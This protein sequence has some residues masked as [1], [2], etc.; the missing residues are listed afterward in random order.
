MF[1]FNFTKILDGFLFIEGN[2]SSFFKINKY[3]FTIYYFM[4]LFK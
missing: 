3:N 1:C 2:Q 4:K